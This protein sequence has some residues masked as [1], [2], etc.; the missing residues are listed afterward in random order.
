MWRLGRASCAVQPGSASRRRTR[1]RSG[2]SGFGS[3]EA[4]L[5]GAGQRTSIGIGQAG[6]VRRRRG[7]R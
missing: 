1:F 4:L 5:G 2:E 3:G 7:F 6:R